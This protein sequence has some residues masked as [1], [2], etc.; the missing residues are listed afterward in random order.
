MVTC[1]V[2]TQK[3]CV[4]NVYIVRSHIPIACIILANLGLVRHYSQTTECIYT[5]VYIGGTY[6]NRHGP[7]P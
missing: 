3:P 7:L 5:F 4:G 6:Y 1:D 2:Y